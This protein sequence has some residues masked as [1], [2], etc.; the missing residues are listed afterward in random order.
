MLGER[1]VDTR[2]DAGVALGL[3]QLLQR[4]LHKLAAR[5][6]APLGFTLGR[7]EQLIGKGDGTVHTQSTTDVIPVGKGP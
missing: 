5:H 4:R 3:Q 7:G 1:P 2:C 6:P